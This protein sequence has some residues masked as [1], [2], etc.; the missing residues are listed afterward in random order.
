M[1]VA[2]DKILYE[3]AQKHSNH[4]ALVFTFFIIVVFIIWKNPFKQIKPW[5]NR[6]KND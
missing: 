4:L 1:T 2:N 3:N 5:I 6:I